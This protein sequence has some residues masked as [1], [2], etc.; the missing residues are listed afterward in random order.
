MNCTKEKR[1]YHV[2]PMQNEKTKNLYWPTGVF[3]IN[4]SNSI[5][6]LITHSLN[7]LHNCGVKDIMLDQKF[8]YLVVFEMSE[9][10]NHSRLNSRYYYL[11]T[12]WW[13]LTESLK[14]IL[15]LI[16]TKIHFLT[17][18]AELCSQ[19]SH[20]HNTLY[21]PDCHTHESFVITPFLSVFLT[22]M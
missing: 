2:S 1:F 5:A 12:S 19:L 4:L 15:T 21:V 7:L 11:F 9:L 13:T 17:F 18:H 8:K 20:P 14:F 3:I 10:L 22:T 6:A 16:L